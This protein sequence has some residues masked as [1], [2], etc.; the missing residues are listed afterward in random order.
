MGTKRTERLDG[1]G[2]L[3]GPFRFS[4]AP[5]MG[6]SRVRSSAGDLFVR[7]Y[8]FGVGRNGRRED[9]GPND[10]HK[11]LGSSHKSGRQPNQRDGRQIRTENARTPVGHL[12]GRRCHPHLWGARHYELVTVDTC[13]WHCVQS[14]AQL[15][16]LEPFVLSFA[17][18]HDFG[19]CA[20]APFVRSPDVLLYFLKPL[21]FVRRPAVTKINRRR[22]EKCSS[23]STALAAMENGRKRTQSQRSRNPFM[24]F[25]LRRTT[26]VCITFWPWPAKTFTYL[27][28]NRSMCF[29]DLVSNVSLFII[30]F[31]VF[32][33][34]MPRTPRLDIQ[35]VARFSDHN[36]TVWRTAW[37]VTGTMLASTGD[38]GYVR[39]WRGMSRVGWGAN[40]RKVTF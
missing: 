35:M 38:D 16:H 10:A 1:D 18:A 29:Y 27:R 21:C 5:V 30:N 14:A 3:E 40:V 32:S 7:S 23:L 25:R 28:L 31:F 15:S 34:E 12:L 20:L 36:C 6:S 17:S 24:T 19:E 9:N 8:R 26:A 39:M 33:R 37:N 2:Q 22:A 11:T 13:V 4:L